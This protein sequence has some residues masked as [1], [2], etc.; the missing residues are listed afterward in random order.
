MMTF[1][2]KYFPLSGC[3]ACA[4]LLAAAASSAVCAASV[5]IGG[6]YDTG[7]KYTFANDGIHGTET[8]LGMESSMLDSSRFAIRAHE[9][10]SD[11]LSVGFIAESGFKTDSGQLQEQDIFFN[12]GS[13]FY[14]SHK[15]YG[16]L[17]MG[18]L[19]T[20]RSGA[21]PAG[22]QILGQRTSPFGSG[23]DGYGAG[24][25]YAM[26]F[27][28]FSVDNA[29]LYKSPV[30]NGLQLD[31]ETS[32]GGTDGGDENKANTDRYSAA[33]LT[34][35]R[36]PLRLVTVLEYMNE[37]SSKGS[38]DDEIAVTV[39]G[40]YDFTA[41]EL[42]GWAQYFR[43]ANHIMALSNIGDYPLFT[44]LD[45]MRGFAAAVSAKIPTGHGFTDLAL[46]WLDAKV[47]DDVEAADEDKVGSSLKRFGATIAYEYPLSGQAMAG[48]HINF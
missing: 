15:Q 11:Q 20:M 13:L 31:I 25:L 42:F 26:P 6:M 5:S 19:G 24:A 2:P 3:A 7:L 9:D 39:G 44:G 45:D 40:S 41:F 1:N 47:H 21:T 12:L 23:W 8:A 4:A 27:I 10:I 35:D 32:F 48:I 36:G 30:I 17:W 14:L 37:N 18:R 22:F 29:L 16:E 38:R 43:G 46:S 34:Y 28:G 33:A